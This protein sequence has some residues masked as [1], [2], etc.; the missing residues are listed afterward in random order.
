MLYYVDP[1]NREVLKY[2]ERAQTMEEARARS[3]FLNSCAYLSSCFG[4]RMLRYPRLT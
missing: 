2:P 1:V 4:V 3:W